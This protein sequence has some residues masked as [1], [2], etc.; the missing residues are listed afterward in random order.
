MCNCTRPLLNHSKY[1]WKWMAHSTKQH[2]R[3]MQIPWPQQ[4]HNLFAS[5]CWCFVEPHRAKAIP[6][7]VCS[8]RALPFEIEKKENLCFFFCKFFSE[9]IFLL[10]WY[11]NLYIV[12][13]YAIEKLMLNYDSNLIRIQYNQ[14]KSFDRLK[15]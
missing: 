10:L 1:I 9:K 8:L 13:L 5:I 4:L 14:T 2:T 3:S 7:P 6:T 11:I 15:I 12:Y